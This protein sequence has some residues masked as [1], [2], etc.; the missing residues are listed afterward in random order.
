MAERLYLDERDLQR[1]GISE[2]NIRTIRKL[3]EFVDTQTRLAE[4]E[5]E[6]AVLDA[7][8]TA[9]DGTVAA[10]EAA[11][12]A[13]DLR[14]DAYDAL[15]PFVRQ[16]Q[17]AAWV[18]ASGTAARTTFA[19]YSSPDIS[20]AYVEAEVQAIADH[21]QILSQRLKAIIDDLKSNGALT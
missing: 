18:V 9:L 2:P 11:I 1:V 20:A 17:G 21:V 5:A 19:T 6:A 16:D 8:V 3:A 15:A 14:I 12:V 4:A 13:L 7:T 10:A